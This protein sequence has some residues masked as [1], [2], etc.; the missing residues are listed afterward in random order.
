MSYQLNSHD[1]ELLL[2]LGYVAETSQDLSQH[3]MP[4]YRG[5]SGRS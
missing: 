2:E 5:T 3:M 4:R 1:V